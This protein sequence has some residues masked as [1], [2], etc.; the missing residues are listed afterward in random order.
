MRI[1]A[2]FAVLAT[3]M[4][5]A[6]APAAAKQSS[7]G[8]P[9]GFLWGTAVS[10]FQT[11]AGASAAGSDP[12]T[13]WWVWVH[14]QANIDAG[15][16]SGDLPEDGPG[17][18]D[19]FETDLALAHK[20]K[21]NAFRTG[22][23]WSRIFPSSTRTVDASGGI[24]EDVL[25]RLDALANQDAVAHYRQVFETA[26]KRHL[27]LLVTLNH[28]SLPLWIH[29]PIAVRDALAGVSPNEL[30]SDLGGP[31]GW[32]DADTADQFAKYAAYVAWKFG[33]LV[34]LWSPINEPLVVATSGYVN[35][36]GIPG[37][38]PPGALN[39]KA[40]I[41]AVLNMVRGNAAAH[42]AVKAWDRSD[43]DRDGEA[44]QVGL[45]QNLVAFT[46]TDPTKSN[47]VL[48]TAHADYLF[49]RMFV[50]AAVRGEIDVNANGSI[51]PGESHPELA[52]KA[53][54]IGVNYY[55]R[56]RVTGLG[57]AIT[58]VIPVLD[59][60]PTT[61]YR[62]PQNPTAPECPTTCSEL[63][64]EIYPEGLRQVLG[65]AGGYGLPVY[66]TENGIA[67]SNDDQ[68][69]QYL[70]DHL[71]VLRQAI[72][73][74]VANV[75]GYFHWSLLDNFEWSSGYYPKFGLYSYDHE[76][77]AREARPSARLYRR[78]AQKNALPL[79]R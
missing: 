65:T 57:V 17:S 34:D 40:V 33:D 5:V 24:T 3:A 10:G 32:L 53:D 69:P 22:I 71:V 21:T 6:A 47:D 27:E 38:F 58:P 43:A 52:G 19:L 49:N 54:F 14:D 67:D 60:V 44:A 59:F 23:E 51:E 41:T 25:R 55:L 42:D 72:A 68:R 76:S 1:C 39:F 11:E 50:N 16:V 2:T 7:A 20:L 64:W 78:I 62:T 36:P 26:R 61:G 18:Y 48:G 77:L 79:P 37:G 73:D 63:G 66:I 4:L 70:L 28:F 46:P 12:N 31:A 13:D 29:D 56:A 74:G 15:R 30:P 35:L 75:R 8:F 45:V 9:D